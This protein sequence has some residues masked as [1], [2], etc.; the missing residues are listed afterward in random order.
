[1]QGDHPGEGSVDGGQHG[2]GLGPAVHSAIVVRGGGRAVRIEQDQ[3][4][5]RSGG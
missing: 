4:L 3:T 1:M 5:A 2:G